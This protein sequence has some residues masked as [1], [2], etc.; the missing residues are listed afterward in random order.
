[1][2]LQIECPV[3][4]NV[5]QV[6]EG[7]TEDLFLAL[8]PP[9]PKVRLQRFD[10]CKTNDVVSLELNFIFFKQTW[11]SLITEDETNDTT[12]RF[13]DEGTSLPFFLS[14]WRHHHLVVA[15]GDGAK[16]IDD[17]T[18]KTPWWLPAWLMY[19]AMY[20]QFLYRKPVYKRY[21]KR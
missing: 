2:R 21:F 17:I 6:K 13:V 5:L 20:F 19:P 9:F 7:F 4:K 1:M 8:N 14:A 18:F 10:G 11:E 16:I 15:D 12:F 3:E